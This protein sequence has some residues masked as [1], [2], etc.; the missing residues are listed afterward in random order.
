LNWCCLFVILSAF[1][2][3]SCR[4]P[5]EPPASTPALILDR[6]LP[7]DCREAIVYF[8]DSGK[9]NRYPER[10]VGTF[11]RLALRNVKDSAA[12]AAMKC[13]EGQAWNILQKPDSMLSCFD[14]A[15]PYLEAH[16]ELIDLRTLSYLY[17]GCAHF[18]K[19][20][21]LTATYFFNKAGNELEDTE[22]VKGG[23]EFIVTGYS[24]RERVEL[25]TKIATHAHNSGVHEQ[26]RHY[27]KSALN[28]S[29]QLAKSRPDLRA[30]ALMAAGLI[31][32]QGHR[33]D[34]GDAYFRQ[35]VPIIARL[36]DTALWMTYYDH[37]GEAYLTTH[38]YDSSLSSYLK[39]LDLQETTGS[40]PFEVAQ[41][42]EGIANSYLGLGRPKMA[43]DAILRAKPELYDDTTAPVPERLSFAKSYLKYLTFASTGQPVFEGFVGLSDSV[44]DQARIEAINDMDAQYS[45]QKKEARIQK[46]NKENKEISERVK[47]QQILLVVFFLIIALL[48]AVLALLQQFQR[49]RRLQT[50]RDKAVLEQRLLRS[51]ME[52]HFLFN[53]ISV[54]QSL[55]RQNQRDQS[56]KYL[57]RF[58]RL[59]RISLENAR[60][61]FVPLTVEIEALQYYLSLQQIRFRDV[62][63]YEIH[64]Y[65]G[66]GEEAEELRIPPMLLQPFVENAIQHGVSNMTNEEGFIKVT[67][68]KVGRNLI[69]L[70]EDN[71]R[72]QGV[73]RALNPEKKNS[74]STT[75]TRERLDLL[76]RQSGQP[77]SLDVYRRLPA[78]G[79]GMVVRLVI[80]YQ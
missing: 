41:T 23:T 30:S 72:E 51:Q 6:R 65:D 11:R 46:L 59:L 28:L 10:A 57:S 16:P 44:F 45:L 66:Y 1:G 77:A 20:N 79:G 34:S 50:E 25:F 68:Q 36:Q 7:A 9:I 74:L 17:S 54:L 53:T 31:Y 13:Y 27:I 35:A 38:K 21:R 48:A 76:S 14:A 12:F 70:I 47:T 62:F 64:T 80:P 73:V 33:T 32:S 69:F 39:L 55:V 58:A 22:Y 78:E 19:K 2:L 60:E 42:E 29:E 4:Q 61:E 37:R 63:R 56:I 26:A 40:P 24:I 67:V 8:I 15:S 75:I 5:V 49:R 71:G 18:Y 43:R 52:P 3:G